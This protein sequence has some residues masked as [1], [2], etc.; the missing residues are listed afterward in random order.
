MLK[1]IISRFLNAYVDDAVADTDGNN[2]GKTEVITQHASNCV[3]EK[4]VI[5]KEAP[6]IKELPKEP[7]VVA[8]AKEVP[9]A[10]PVPQKSP[11]TPVSPDAI[12]TD[13]GKMSSATSDKLKMLEDIYSSLLDP[14]NVPSTSRAT[15]ATTPPLNQ[16]LSNV[17]SLLSELR[18]AN[19]LKDRLEVLCRDLSNENHR[20]KLGLNPVG[21][22]LPPDDKKGGKKKSKGKEQANNSSG[23]T[24]E[25]YSPLSVPNMP[26]PTWNEVSFVPEDDGVLASLD[27]DRLLEVAK[28]ARQQ[29]N[30]RECQY[31]AVLT[32]ERLETH[33]AQAQQAMHAL[34]LHRERTTSA[35]LTRRLNASM[36]AEQD[37]RAQLTVYMEKFRQVEDT[38]ARS[39]DLFGAFRAEIASVGA[40]LNKSERECSALKAKNET[41]SRNILTMAEERE[42]QSQLAQTLQKQKDKLE[43]LCRTLQAERKKDSS[44]AVPTTVEKPAAEAAKQ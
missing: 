43:S 36:A 20:L 9:V 44:T 4:Q 2:C 38:L 28:L 17:A 27:R 34:A 14:A 11:V 18:K 21:V 23:K 29:Y 31:G 39:N 42:K 22:L 12:A 6:A 30:Q 24:A 26:A 13:H 5:T 3:A 16:P 33:L 32:A 15:P 19:L 25:K 35:L 40:K 37:L 8:V 7:S 1:S 41:L 10:A